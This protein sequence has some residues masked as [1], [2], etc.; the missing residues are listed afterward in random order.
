MEDLEFPVNQVDHRRQRRTL[1]LPGDRK[2]APF[3]LMFINLLSVLKVER[4]IRGGAG[5]G[6]R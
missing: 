5:S 4:R 2:P 6:I 3:V 1:P